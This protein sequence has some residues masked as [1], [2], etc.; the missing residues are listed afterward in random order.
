MSGPLQAED[1]TTDPRA[2]PDSAL[3][4]EISESRLA[5][6]GGLQVRRALPRRPRRT[7]GSWCFADH[8]GPAQ[9]GGNGG[10]GIGPHPHMGLQTVT[11]LLAGELVHHDSLGS[12]QSI[13]PGQ[14]NLMTAGRGVAHAEEGS[15]YRGE[16]HGIQLWVAQ[17]EAT[18]WA[19]PAFEHHRE[20]PLVELDGAV[21][22][23]LVGDYGAGQSPARR[24][25]EN[26]GADL[27]LRSPGCVMPLNPSYEHAFIVLSG[28]LVLEGQTLAPGHLAYLRAGRDECE[29]DVPEP[30]RALL[31][32]GAPFDEAVFM[33]WN[34]VGRSREEMADAYR[35]W[36]G[37]DGW[38]GAVRSAL[39]RIPV[40]PPPWL[41]GA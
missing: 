17:P 1:V 26:F 11:W 10:F 35:H 31:L 37:D 41:A 32:G 6:V 19:D 4:I 28:L 38:F 5:D 33:W 24:D 16:L 9:V 2:A 7:V 34:F 12:E 20:L 8:M 15:D 13:K 18:R 3:S 39:A 27:D 14:L 21:A 22:T 36:A 25:T 40:D 23:V 30:T 29:V